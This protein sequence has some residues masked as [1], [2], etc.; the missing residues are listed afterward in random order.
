[1]IQELR[2]RETWRQRIEDLEGQ[3]ERLKGAL[4]AAGVNPRL[5]ERIAK[6]EADNW[7]ASVPDTTVDL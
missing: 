7:L 4:I 3:V 2:N 1:M 5:V 6:N